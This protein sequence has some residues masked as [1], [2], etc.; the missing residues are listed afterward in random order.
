MVH[1]RFYVFHKTIY[2]RLLIN[3]IPDKTVSDRIVRLILDRD[4]AKIEVF[5][6]KK[7]FLKREEKKRENSYKAGPRSD[8][9]SQ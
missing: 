7:T 8:E 3:I 4:Y 2:N 1:S 6:K 5:N 9:N